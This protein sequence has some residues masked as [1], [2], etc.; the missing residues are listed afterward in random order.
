[1]CERERHLL[2]V[3]GLFLSGLRC[4]VECLGSLGRS[5]KAAKILLSTN[6]WGKSL[7]YFVSGTG[8]PNL[9]LASAGP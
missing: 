7:L 3:G 1:M 8:A 6:D 9:A 5:W 4:D 2:I